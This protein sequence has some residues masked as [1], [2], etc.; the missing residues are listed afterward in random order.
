MQDDRRALA[1][2]QRADGVECRRE[3]TGVL[4]DAD[5]R[6]HLLPFLDRHP[7]ALMTQLVDRTVDDDPLQPRAERSFRVE[8]IKC[9]ERF[10]DRFLRGLVREHPVTDDGVCPLPRK[11]PEALKERADGVLGSRP[12]QHD[13]LCFGRLQALHPTRVPS[14]QNNDPYPRPSDFR[15]VNV[16]ESLTSASLDRL[17]IE[18]TLTLIRDWPKPSPAAVTRARLVRRH[19]CSVVPRQPRRA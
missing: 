1:P 17:R 8:P 13:H 16:N 11:G 19:S 6:T 15:C 5:R 18:Q 14:L 12:C 3:R 2:R 4:V 7:S 10:D 9:A